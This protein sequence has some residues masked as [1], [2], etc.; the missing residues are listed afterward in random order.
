VNFD[1]DPDL[2]FCKENVLWRLKEKSKNQILADGSLYHPREIIERGRV[3][4][5]GVLVFT[6]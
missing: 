2:D 3:A 4:F 5:L 6:G 1:S